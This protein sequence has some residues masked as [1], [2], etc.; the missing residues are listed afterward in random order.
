[1]IPGL[2]IGEPI[3]IWPVGIRIQGLFL[4]AR[5]L[6]LDLAL[7]LV[8]LAGSAGAGTHWGSDWHHH[9]VIYNHNTYV[10][11]SRSSLIKHVN[12]ERANFK[13]GGGFQRG[14]GFQGRGTGGNS[15]SKS[16]SR[17]SPAHGFGSSAARIRA[18]TCQSGGH[19][20]AFG[21]LL[22]MEELLED[23]PL[24]GSLVSAASRWRRWRLH[25]GGG[26][27][28]HGRRSCGEVAGNSAHS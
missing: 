20:G 18:P 24:A 16:G 2:R 27:G 12:R 26:G 10:S 21:G 8:I 11:H 15:G 25:G 22:I 19:S 5:E 13:H 6:R 17:I 1:M 9:D 7:E 28:F 23:S 14:H 4:R 3:G